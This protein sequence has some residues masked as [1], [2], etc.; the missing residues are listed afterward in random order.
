MT[1]LS[2]LIFAAVLVLGGSQ[3]RR[4]R[5]W[6]RA[7]RLGI[8]AWQALSLA[9]IS[10]VTL[11][12]LTL[13]VPTSSLGWDLA[14]LIEACVFTLQAAYAAPSELPGVTAGAVLAV[15][16]TAW[17]SG[18]VSL[19]LARAHRERARTHDALALV[20]R[21]DA[22][23]GAAVVETEVAAAYCLPGRHERVVLTTAAVA[24][25]DREELAAVIAHERAHLRQ[26]HHLALASAH[27]LARAFPG[28]PLFQTGVVEIARLLELAAG[29]AAATDTD[30]VSV[31]GA[32]VTLAGMSAPA[33]ALAAAS[34]VGAVRVKR[35]LE[36]CQAVGL[37]QRGA[38][39][40]GLILI[41]IAPALLAAYPAVAA[42]G[43][44]VCTLPPV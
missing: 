2:L 36:P 43:A 32:L 19:E 7:P 5:L 29:D 18:W 35:L 33:S 38:V 4:V 28:I 15:G 10:A 24:A 34:S 3:V 14:S 11:A 23:L 31:A 12:G 25:L 1:S 13:I 8:L 27:G 16:T 17:A 22:S 39:L 44:D 42:A 37:V 20:S 21:H 30:G 6:D 26:R 40:A 41:V 9:S